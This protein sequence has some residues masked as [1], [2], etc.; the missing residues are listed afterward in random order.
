MSK[1]RNVRGVGW[2]VS[3]IGNGSSLFSSPYKTLYC[4]MMHQ[5]LCL[6]FLTAVW[7]GAKLADVLELLG[8]PK[9]TASTNLGGRHVEFVSVDRCK[10]KISISFMLWLSTHM[11]LFL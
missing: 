1:V 3:A 10:V 2:D 4:I 8:I 7:A 11:F 6:E 5:R 9:L